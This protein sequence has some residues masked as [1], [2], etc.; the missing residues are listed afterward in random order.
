MEV[1]LV[2]GLSVEQQEAVGVA[3]DTVTET[4]AFPQQA[5]LPNHVGCVLRGRQVGLVTKRLDRAVVWTIGL[6]MDDRFRLENLPFFYFVC[7]ILRFWFDHESN[8]WY[9][10]WFAGRCRVFYDV[11][12]TLI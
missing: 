4:V 11:V 5:T 3:R 8:G 1:L 10:D 7:E 2:A 6:C 9:G 12:T